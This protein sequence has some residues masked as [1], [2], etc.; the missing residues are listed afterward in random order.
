MEWQA[1]TVVTRLRGLVALI[2]RRIYP[3]QIAARMSDEPFNPVRGAIVAALAGRTASKTRRYSQVWLPIA[4]S[5]RTF[6]RS[7]TPEMREVFEELREL[8]R[9]G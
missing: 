6:C 8:R 9:V 5:F 7:P 4:D 1:N 2:F 3:I